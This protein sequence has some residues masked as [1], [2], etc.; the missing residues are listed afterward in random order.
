MVPCFSDYVFL[1]SVLHQPVLLRN[2]VMQPR[3][4]SSNEIGESETTADLGDKNHIQSC[5][6]RLIIC[7][8]ESI[9]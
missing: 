7:S 9:L 6:R 3:F 8:N 1:H 5:D 4:L 2:A